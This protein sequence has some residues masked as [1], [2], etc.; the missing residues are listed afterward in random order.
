MNDSQP[1]RKKPE[2][3]GKKKGDTVN[4]L[5]EADY[6]LLVKE[7]IELSLKGVSDWNIKNHLEGKGLSYTQSLNVRKRA[8]DY[9]L[10]VYSNKI[11]T[12]IERA[13]SQWQQILE[14]SLKDGDRRSAI[15][16]RENIDKISGLY[17]VK[18][19][20]KEAD[21]IP[22]VI[23]ITEVIKEEDEIENN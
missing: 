18:F 23:E 2:G 19:Q 11:H 14:L 20:V 12:S 1:K 21:A 7:T 8:N 3:S 16:A 9:V 4:Q 10:K 22:D 17:I 15:K 13:I 6:I 5:S